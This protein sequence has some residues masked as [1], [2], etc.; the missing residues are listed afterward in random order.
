MDGLRK[1]DK[2]KKNEAEEKAIR[3]LGKLGPKYLL[4]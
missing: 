4:F 1:E 3:S 2:T